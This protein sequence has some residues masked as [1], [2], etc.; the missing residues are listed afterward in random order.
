MSDNGGAIT[1]LGELLDRYQAHLARGANNSVLAFRPLAKSLNG[2][3]EKDPARIT[4]EEWLE[5]FKEHTTH[6]AP[7]TRSLRLR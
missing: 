5:W 6:L 4:G 7:G 2:W 3:R 1:T